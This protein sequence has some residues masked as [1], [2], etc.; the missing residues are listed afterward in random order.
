MSLNQIFPKCWSSAKLH[1]YIFAFQWVSERKAAHDNIYPFCD[2]SSVEHTCTPDYTRVTRCQRREYSVGV[3]PETF[4][5]H[6]VGSGTNVEMLQCC[7]V[8]MLQCCNV[9]MLQCCNVAKDI[10]QSHINRK[11]TQDN[12]TTREQLQCRSLP[13]Q[14]LLYDVWGRRGLV[15]RHSPTLRQFLS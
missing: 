10:I 13:L 9:A 5:Y 2:V 12:F 11:Q 6:A 8:A 1:L 7:N 3:V 15:H 14:R 4:I